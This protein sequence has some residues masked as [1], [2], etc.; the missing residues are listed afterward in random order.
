LTEFV[1]LISRDALRTAVSALKAGAHDYLTYPIQD[2]DVRMAA[3]SFKDA[4]TRNMELNYLRDRFWKTDWL[5]VIQSRNKAM[6]RVFEN[7]RAVAPTIATVLLLGETGTGKG[8]L[9]R[10]LHVHSNRSEATFVAVHCGAIPETLLESELFGHEKGAFTGAIR[11]KLGKFELARNGTIFLDEIGTVAAPAQVK[12][13]QVL[14]DGTFSRV[15]G[16]EQLTTKARIIAATNAD[17]AELT[18]Q[19]VFRKDLYYRLNVF[20]IRI[21]PL[22]ERLED[23]PHLIE[24]FLNRLNGRYGKRIHD[25]HPSVLEAFRSY[26][27]PGNIRELENVLE[28]AYI[29]ET[30]EKLMPHRFPADLI[31][32]CDSAGSAASQGGLSLSEARH[33][34]IEAFEKEYVRNLLSN[35]A[36]R[37]SRSAAEADITPRQLNRLMNRYGIDKGEFKP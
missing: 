28:R 37:I 13:L 17:L 4:L 3:L 14:Q 12:L 22:R 30:G 24:V 1:V 16:E 10:L 19:G 26:D 27:W 5:D 32:V 8:L 35:N 33:R 34:A 7:V 15:G 6:G 29:L 2:A 31:G 9:A 25:V 18:G 21:P 11:R 20:P 36:G 23:L